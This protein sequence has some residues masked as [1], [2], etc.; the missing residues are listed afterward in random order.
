M[1]KSASSL[2]CWYTV[3]APP[4]NLKEIAVAGSFILNNL[5]AHSVFSSLDRQPIR[6]PIKFQYRLYVESIHLYANVLML[7]RN[8]V[9]GC[10]QWS[11]ARNVTAHF[12]QLINSL[13]PAVKMTNNLPSDVS[14]MC[15]GTVANWPLLVTMHDIVAPLQ[16]WPC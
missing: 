8:W 10:C 4:V 6:R 3:Y 16:H 11:K 15:S 5:Q 12:A 14:C 1:S 2:N 13:T 9:E 7:N